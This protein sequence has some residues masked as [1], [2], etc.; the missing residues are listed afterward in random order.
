MSNDRVFKSGVMNHCYQRSE[1]GFVL[2]YTV[3]DCLVYFTIYCIAAMQYGIQVHAM[4]QMPDHVHDSVT[5]NN[6]S[7]LAAFKKH[8]NSVFAKAQNPLC[9]FKGKLF[10]KPFGSAPKYTDKAQRSNI[11]YIANNPVERHLCKVAEDFRWNYVAYASSPNPFSP[12]IVL[13][14][15]RW[16]L[17]NAVK[18][19]KE[20]HL[21]QR[22]LNYAQ[23]KR[24]FAPL[25]EVERRQLTDFIITTYNV[26]DYES[27]IKRFGSYQNM[28]TAFHSTTGSEHDLH[29][30]FAGTTDSEYNKIYTLLMQH[31]HAT[32]IH[33]ILGYDHDTKMD[34]YF[35]L[36]GSCSQATSLQIAKYLRME[37]EIQQF[38]THRIKH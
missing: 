16:C 18:E 33:D 17:R 36:R 22:H 13:R 31:T 35:L 21:A 38:D 12:K 11:V 5:A 28:L 26:I 32:D 24:L 29:E 25:K 3:S 20:C 1:K 4:C 30:T 15:C 10:E 23:L 19:V 7:T 34:L 8:V 6:A 9:G 27:V 37:R 14:E 2:F